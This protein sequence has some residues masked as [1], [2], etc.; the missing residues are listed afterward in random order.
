[1]L[2]LHGGADLL[3][4]LFK[5]K[6]IKDLGNVNISVMSSIVQTHA[7]PVGDAQEIGMH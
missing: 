3:G 2:P 4:G 1:M 6:Y 5:K 7:S